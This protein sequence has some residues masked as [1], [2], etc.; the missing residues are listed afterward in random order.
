M[1]T[2]T[3]DRVIA[4]AT[5]EFA[6][7]GYAG[8]RIDRIAASAHASKERLYAWFGDKAKLY[9]LVVEAAFA[10]NAASVRF[11][12]HDLPGFSRAFYLNLVGSPT[13]L[14]LLVWEQVETHAPRVLGSEA[15]QQVT[16]A[17][18]AEIDAAQKAGTL[19][20]RFSAYDLNALIFA[21]AFAWATIPRSLQGDS[22]EELDRRADVIAQAVALLI[23]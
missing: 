1:T 21:T 7:Y 23:A 11:D 14:R 18:I 8:A 22:A 12:V 17:R 15:G 6:E 16:L 19:S 3:R 13:A 20:D 10:R 9:S 4:A 2:E 5:E